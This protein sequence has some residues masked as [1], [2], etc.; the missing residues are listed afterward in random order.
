MAGARIGKDWF[1]VC[2]LYVLICYLDCVSVFADCGLFSRSVAFFAVALLSRLAC[3]WL[4]VCCGYLCF[5]F[6]EL[7]YYLMLAFI[8]FR[9]SEI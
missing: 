3:L 5:V 7:F 1:L 8:I 6:L 2:G 4:F 9:L